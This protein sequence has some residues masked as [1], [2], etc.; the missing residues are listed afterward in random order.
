M[1]PF[2]YACLC[3]LLALSACSNA[4][5]K[6]KQPAAPRKD[7]VKAK[8]ADPP[9]SELN[10]RKPPIV[11]IID[12][13]SPKRTVVYM[14]DSASTTERVGLKLAQIYGV[15]LAAVFKQNKGLKMAGQ[16][17]A[18][19]RSQK[20]PFFFEAG[21]PV[22]KRPAKLG[23]GIMVKEVPADSVIMAHF[24][25][26]YDLTSQ[27]YDAIKERLKDTRRTAKGRPYEIYISDPMD[28][29]GKPV[30][31][32]RVQTDIIFPRH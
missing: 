1:K 23:P 16:P 27:G 25:G 4:D 5:D 31:P 21:V 19:Y 9:P 14:K 18:W 22:N 2:G 8:K 26:P 15:K 29:K 20:A 3:L 17:M 12:T 6:K 30:D 28:K 24:F 13:V 10:I 7:T 32:Y 11:N